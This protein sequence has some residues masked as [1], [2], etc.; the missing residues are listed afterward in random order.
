MVT[1]VWWRVLGSPPSGVS[2]GQ[3]LMCEQ[4]VGGG[5]NSGPVRAIIGS[6]LCRHLVQAGPRKSRRMKPG[7]ACN[8]VITRV[9]RVIGFRV[10]VTRCDA[11]G[12]GVLRHEPAAAIHHPPH[13][14]LP[15]RHGHR[16]APGGLYCRCAPQP[17][18]TPSCQTLSAPRYSAMHQ[19]GCC[20][21][22][23]RT[24]A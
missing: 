4:R 15:V 11:A 1:A 3:V 20:A 2:A 13:R 17:F 9:F 22:L 12:V 16:A 24:S 8:I 23:F 7:V 10:K 6:Q 19:D 14:R 21:L 5:G 18:T